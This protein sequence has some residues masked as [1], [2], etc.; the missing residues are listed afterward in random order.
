[1][2]PLTLAI[3][4]SVLHM[5]GADATV[6]SD[7]KGIEDLLATVRG[8]LQEQIDP[9]SPRIIEAAYA[10]SYTKGY[11]SRL[12]YGKGTYAKGYS[13]YGLEQEHRNPTALP[14]GNSTKTTGASRR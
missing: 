4:A 14:G 6:T 9:N 12:L 10:K 13:K 2:P 7:N 1:M 5:Q 8:E 3:L 11:Y